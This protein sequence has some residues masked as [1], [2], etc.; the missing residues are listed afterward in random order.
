MVVGLPRPSEFLGEA[1]GSKAPA[2]NMSVGAA[3]APRSNGGGTPSKQKD[4]RV[5]A[6]TGDVE[7]KLSYAVEAVG[8][9]EG[10]FL[11]CPSSSSSQPMAFVTTWHATVCMTP[12]PCCNSKRLLGDANPRRGETAEN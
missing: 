11:A 5:E 9:E 6:D 4:L 3:A 7:G 8:D 12:G 10:K 1:E 2:G